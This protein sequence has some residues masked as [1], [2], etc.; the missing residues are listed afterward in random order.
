MP[1]LVAMLLRRNLVY[2]PTHQCLIILFIHPTTHKINLSIHI[3]TFNTLIMCIHQ[4]LPTIQ[5]GYKFAW[6][7]LWT[8]SIWK[9]YKNGKK[10]FLCHIG[11]QVRYG[12]IRS[13]KVNERKGV[14]IHWFS[15]IECIPT[16]IQQGRELII[17]CWVKREM[18]TFN[19]LSRVFNLQLP[20]HSGDRFW[21]RYRPYNIVTREN[22][23]VDRIPFQ[24]LANFEW[25]KM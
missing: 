17:I 3:G 1:P 18:N 23:T 13:E 9:G 6:S 12:N 22:I 19:F 16:P 25:G 2:A 10:V 8:S 11:V 7:A 5:K 21:V 15:H 24:R 20:G 4:E 14:K